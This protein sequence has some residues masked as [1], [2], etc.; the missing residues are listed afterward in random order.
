[1]GEQR[2]DE[3]HHGVGDRGPDPLRPLASGDAGGNDRRALRSLPF[4][5][6]LLGRGYRRDRWQLLAGHQ[7]T[8][9]LPNSSRWMSVTVKMKANRTTPTA[10]AYPNEMLLI[11]WL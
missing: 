3:E 2:G 4:A 1:D 8:S 5:R 9:A 10:A 11:A 6:E 7:A